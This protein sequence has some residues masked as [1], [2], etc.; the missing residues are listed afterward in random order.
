MNHEFVG[1]CNG[2]G[3]KRCTADHGTDADCWAFEKCGGCSACSVHYN[4]DTHCVSGEHDIGG[5][6]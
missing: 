1:D 6:G 4:F 2:I 5:E 3:I